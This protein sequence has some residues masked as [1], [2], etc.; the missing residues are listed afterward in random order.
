MRFKRR[1]EL[2]HGFKHVEIAPLIDMVF[3]L[4]IFF[5]LTSN[6]VVQPGL[7]V[8]LPT[9]QTGMFLFPDNIVITISG[10]NVVYFNGLPISTAELKNLISQAG[11]R[12][13]P[14][15]LKADAKASLGKAVEIWDMSRNLGVTQINMATDQIK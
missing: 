14:V 6:F 13:Q 9:T 5:L 4:L 8:N 2:E 15:L 1:I 10:E 11:R 7:K 3:L 12:K